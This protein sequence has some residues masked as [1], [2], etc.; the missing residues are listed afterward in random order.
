[1]NTSEKRP[2]KLFKCT[3]ICLKDE[4]K[5]LYNSAASELFIGAVGAR[6]ILVNILTD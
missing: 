2:I 1:M 3:S 4:G 6:L 5:P